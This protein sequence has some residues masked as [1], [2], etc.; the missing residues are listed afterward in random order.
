MQKNGMRLNLLPMN[1]KEN[2][3]WLKESNLTEIVPELENVID[4]RHLHHLYIPSNR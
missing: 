3:F 1:M 2:I 4:H